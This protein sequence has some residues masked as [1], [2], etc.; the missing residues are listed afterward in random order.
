MDVSIW[1]D[2]NRYSGFSSLGT[3]TVAQNILPGYKSIDDRDTQ[4]TQ[5]DLGQILLS[6]MAPWYG[7]KIT[8][9]GRITGGFYQYR[10]LAEL[11]TVEGER[12]ISNG[13]MV[14]LMPKN[15]KNPSSKLVVQV[16]GNR[17]NGIRDDAIK[18]VLADPETKQMYAPRDISLSFMGYFGATWF[19]QKIEVSMDSGSL[20]NTSFTP[21][22]LYALEPVL[23]K[24]FSSEISLPEFTLNKMR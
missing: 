2:S 11:P 15:G 23:Q 18:I 20:R 10:T 7:K 13:I 9:K 17:P 4:G 21:G 14:R 5:V 1:K 24:K 3:K 16:V 8:L 6:D 12:V 19:N 22:R